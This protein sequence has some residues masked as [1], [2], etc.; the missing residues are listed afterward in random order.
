MEGEIW[1]VFD[2]L[3]SQPVKQFRPVVLR[4]PRPVKFIINQ[5]E[6]FWRYY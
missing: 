2:D 3:K 4:V 6:E 5:T 1:R